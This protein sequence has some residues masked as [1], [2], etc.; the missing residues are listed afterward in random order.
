MNS[1]PIQNLEHFTNN[2]HPLAYI[3]FLLSSP[4]YPPPDIITV[5][6]FI[7]FLLKLVLPQMCV[8]LS[9][10]YSLLRTKKKSIISYVVFWN[11]LF[12]FSII[13]VKFIHVI[14]WI[15][16]HCITECIYSFS[17]WWTFR[18]FLFF[19]KMRRTAMK[20]HENVQEFF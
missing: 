16:F 11:L 1:H 18:L 20:I 13:S 15:V 4:S 5:P 17:C 2:L 8:S 7:T 14:T 3:S 12:L 19:G 6:V 9:L 10:L